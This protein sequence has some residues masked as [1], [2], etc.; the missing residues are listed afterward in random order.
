MSNAEIQPYATQLLA[1]DLTA[2][3]KERII[4]AEPVELLSDRGDKVLQVVQEADGQ[5]FV[6]RS[7]TDKAV[8]EIEGQAGATMLEAWDIMQGALSEARIPVI[9][10]FLLESIGNY[11]YVAISEHLPD[12]Q[13]LAAA[14]TEVKEEV[15]QGLGRLMTVDGVAGRVPSMDILNEDMFGVTR[16]EQGNPVAKFIDLDPRIRRRSMITADTSNAAF[17]ERVGVLI[18][19]RWCDPDERTPVISAFVKIIAGAVPDDFDTS[20]MTADAFMNIH[21]M[22][23]GVGPE[24]LSLKF[25]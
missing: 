19:N 15:A 3:L 14:P 12:V 11:P 23:Q 25:S 10:G 18:W 2:V 9:R 24:N 17:I 7:F 5:S 22:S 1:D 4:A 20:P 8:D 16:D 6:T 21:M 13:P